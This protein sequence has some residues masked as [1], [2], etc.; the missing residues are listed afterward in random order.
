MTKDDSNKITKKAIKLYINDIMS[1]PSKERMII[2]DGQLET[3][4]HYSI[5]I[6]YGS[7]RKLC[8][9][10]TVI[11]MNDILLTTLKNSAP[12][13]PNLEIERELETGNPFVVSVYMMFN[14]RHLMV[15]II[16]KQLVSQS[17][18][19]LETDVNCIKNLYSKTPS[20]KKNTKLFL[21]SGS[22]IATMY[23]AINT[24]HI[25]Y[26]ETNTFRAEVIIGVFKKLLTIIN[27]EQK[28]GYTTSSKKIEDEIKYI[29]KN[30]NDLFPKL[31]LK[32]IK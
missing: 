11:D 27:K 29:I 18:N 30:T 12:P 31:K 6:L 4:K 8:I 2:S 5:K 20:L 26:F 21:I 14:T 32:R 22:Q 10:D 17:E 9:N 7:L 16:K 15:E 23:E 19:K 24:C 13:P 1:N 28:I 3:I 25:S